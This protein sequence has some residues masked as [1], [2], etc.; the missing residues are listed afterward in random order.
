MSIGTVLFQRQCDASQGG[1][2][3]WDIKL[4]AGQKLDEASFGFS[5]SEGQGAQL[6]GLLLP[7]KGEGRGWLLLGAPWGMRGR[8]GRGCLSFQ[9]QTQ[10]SSL[11][12]WP[13]LHGATWLCS[14]GKAVMG[15]FAGLA[16]NSARQLPGLPVPYNGCRRKCARPRGKESKPKLT[17]LI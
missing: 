9:V 11:Q 3:H 14:L 10:P 1:W 8:A 2:P 16:I 15:R 6:E 13:W 12:P 5:D 7:Q 4:Q 17:Q